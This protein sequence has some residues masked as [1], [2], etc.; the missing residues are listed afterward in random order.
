M[1]VASW[2]Q[3]PKPYWRLQGLEVLFMVDPI[4]EYAVQQLK[5]YE[6]KKLVSVT[7]EGL[8]LEETGAPAV[9][10]HASRGWM[11]GQYE[12]RTLFLISVGVDCLQDKA[13]HFSRCALPRLIVALFNNGTEMLL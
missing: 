4:D 11:R 1:L 5:E 10:C 7:K 3:R 2:S 12:G 9:L 6:G 13:D 8:V